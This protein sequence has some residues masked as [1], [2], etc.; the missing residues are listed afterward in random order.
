MSDIVKGP[1][2]ET[3][4][5]KDVPLFR[6][7][8][9][10]GVTYSLEDLD[11]WCESVERDRRNGYLNPIVLQ[12]T[13]GGPAIGVLARLRRDDDVLRGDMSLLR[14]S[15]GERTHLFFWLTLIVKRID[16]IGASDHHPSVFGFPAIEIPK[17]QEADPS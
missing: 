15:L 1:M 14:G 3:V 8:E 17:A 10:R 12:D 13:P 6:A 11:L 2:S 9:V 7:G 16:S 5:I 4:E